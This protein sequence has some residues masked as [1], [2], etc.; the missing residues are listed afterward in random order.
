MK[1]EIKGSPLPVVIMTLESGESVNTQ[2]GAMSWMSENMKMETN[3]GGGIGKM[4]SRA[5]SGES[6][7]QNVYT[8]KGGPG[9]LA[10]ASTFP[11]DILPV[12][13]NAGR[14]IVAQKS[15]FL[16]SERGVNMEMFFQKKVGAGFFGGEGF[17]MQKFSGNGVVFLEI[18]GSIV[19]YD[20]QAGQSMMID[21]G[22]LAAMD[23]TVSIDIETVKGVG[24][25]LFGGE[26][27]FNTKITGPGH[28]WLQTMPVS[29]V[30]NCLR[31][32][33]PSSS[34]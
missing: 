33:F 12:E 14:T 23:A 31:P 16:A 2:K 3:A 5:F 7:F 11:G 17:I 21:T 26:G 10:C 9:L 8:A 27:F 32:Y 28:V 25:M 19:E 13:V 15:A 24:N 4:F 22:Y 30:A 34:N 20:L 29:Q 1:F 6:M 18:D